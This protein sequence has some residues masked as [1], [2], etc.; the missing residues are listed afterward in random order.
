MTVIDPSYSVRVTRRVLCSHV[1]SRPLRS[2]ALPLALPDGC[3]KNETAL[4]VSS[5]LR[6]RSFG[7]SLHKRQRS[8]PNHTGPSPQRVPE[9]SF[10][11]PALNNRYLVNF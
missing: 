1:A 5:H 6:I 10:S 7:M 8:S 4:V 3:R 2:R 9:A 11:T